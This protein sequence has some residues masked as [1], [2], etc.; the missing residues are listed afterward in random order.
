VGH[1]TVPAADKADQIVKYKELLD[2][3]IIT[4]EE[5]DAKKKQLLGLY[6]YNQGAEAPWLFLMR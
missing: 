4:Q 5:F 2:K 1:Y 6:N 3:D